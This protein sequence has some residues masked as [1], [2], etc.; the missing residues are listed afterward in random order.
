MVS[1]ILTKVSGT[2]FHSILLLFCAVEN[3]HVYA[4]QGL[5]DLAIHLA[6]NFQIKYRVIKHDQLTSFLL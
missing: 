1:P 5:Y 4:R 3:Q 2:S 6:L